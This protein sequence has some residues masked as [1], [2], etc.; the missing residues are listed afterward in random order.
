MGKYSSYQAIWYQENKKKHK[1]NTRLWAEANP[2][3]MKAIRRK[4]RLKKEYNLTPEQYNLLFDK[5]QGCCFICGRHQQLFK[6]HLDVDHCHKTGRV[7]SLLCVACNT[8]VGIYENRKEELENY[9]RTV[10][11]ELDNE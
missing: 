1:E 3:K 4:T 9:L 10:D 8:D 5:Q 11:K 6:R 2:D 7:R